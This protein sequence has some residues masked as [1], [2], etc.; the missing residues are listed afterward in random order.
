LKK[1]NIRVKVKYMAFLIYVLLAFCALSVG[2]IQIALKKGSAAVLGLNFSLNNLLPFI[3]RLLLNKFIWLALCLC[4]VAFLVYNFLLSKTQLNIVYPV[5]VG[6]GVI[7]TAVFSW[8]FFGEKLSLLQ[9]SGALFI[10]LGV[11]LLLF[12]IK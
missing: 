6:C 8:L 2:V 7:L 11:F 4:F 1:E 12:K 3:G 10:I 5:V 9:A